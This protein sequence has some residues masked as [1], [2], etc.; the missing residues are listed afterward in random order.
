[1]ADIAS[2]LITYLKT[3]GGVTALVGTG[4]A[5]RIYYGDAKQGVALP[6]VVVDLKSGTSHEHLNGIS[7]LAMSRVEVNC[8]GAT[9]AAAWAL[10]EAVRLAPLQKYR[11]TM[12]STYVHEVASPDGYGK[13]YIPPVTGDNRKRFNFVRDYFVHY[14]EATS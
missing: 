3:I 12:G 9:S 2:E 4:T 8:Y 5:A 13:E 11:G 6:Y 14:A 1:M 10:A 7:G